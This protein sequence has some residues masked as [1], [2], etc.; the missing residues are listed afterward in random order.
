[1]IDSA[2]ERIGML[3]IKDIQ[4]KEGL[5]DRHYRLLEKIGGGGFSEVW[6]AQD[7]KSGIQVALKIYMG[8]GFLNEEGK[9]MFRDEFVRVSKLTHGNI[10]RINHFD[11][12]M[13]ILFPSSSKEEKLDVP[14]LE[15]PYY[16]KGSATKLIGDIDED[17][18]WRFAGQVASGLAYIHQLKKDNKP[19]P[20]IHSDIKP[21]NVLIGDDGTFMI[22]D[23]G[24]SVDLRATIRPGKNID[25]DSGLT[26]EYADKDRHKGLKPVMA[27]DIWALGASLFEL[28]TGDV[29]FGRMGGLTQETSSHKRPPIKQQ[30]SSS[31]KELI[32]ACLEENPWDRPSAQEIV[33]WAKRR[34]KPIPRP[35]WIK[36][37]IIAGVTIIVAGTTWQFWP[38]RVWPKDDDGTKTE[39][40]TLPPRD[41]V[42]LAKTDEANYIIKSQ[43][44][45][46][47]KENMDSAVVCANKLADAGKQYHE[48][49]AVDGLLESTISEA[50]RRWE[51]SQAIIDDAYKFFA[52]KEQSYHDIEADEPAQKYARCREIIKEYVSTGIINQ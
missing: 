27:T 26:P 28:A 42:M 47:N 6:L 20:I 13:H 7:E 35:S 51:S 17:T 30:L 46:S 29:P 44:E 49:I 1:M 39:E 41:S 25:Q 24:I 15:L 5:I 38:D 40:T 22:T 33:E 52:S 37:G 21:A 19:K 2:C 23:F 43:W 8:A 3:T 48:A 9:E 10:V 31:L 45:Y 4:E 50:A 36:K 16:S 11:D 34:K 32:W 14:Y 12:E 18:L